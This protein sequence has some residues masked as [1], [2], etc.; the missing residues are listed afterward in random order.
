M[1]FTVGLA[2]FAGGLATGLRSYIQATVAQE[3]AIREK[4]RLESA[5]ATLLGE[6][7]AGQ[8]V[9]SERSLVIDGRAV[10]L[11]TT[12]TSLLV[13]PAVDDARTVR[14]AGGRAGLPID[15]EVARDAAG[16]ARLAA[17]MHLNASREDCLRRVL[18][19][20]RGGQPRG[21]AE[22]LP[23]AFTVRPGDQVDIRASLSGDRES[24]LLL[25][26]RFTD[27]RTGWVL[28]DYRRLRGVEPCGL[29]G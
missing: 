16:L 11:V 21:D 7:A 24:V 3:R 9:S 18:T 12:P 4:I 26:A 29:R 23:D 27:A 2:I 25:R 6:L 8:A 17:V 28:H 1:S 10:A 13:D 19:Y 14:E 20:G 5:A 22:A 15:P